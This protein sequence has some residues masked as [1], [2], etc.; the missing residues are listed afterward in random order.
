MANQV[1]SDISEGEVIGEAIDDAHMAREHKK[2]IVEKIADDHD[3]DDI[4][5][6]FLF[7]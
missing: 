3:E 7:S 1:N 6:D 5:E 4:D 2:T